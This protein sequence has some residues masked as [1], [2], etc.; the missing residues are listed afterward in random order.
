M[1]RIYWIDA[2][3]LITAKNGHYGFNLVPK[4]WSWIHKQIESGIVC[5]PKIAYKEIIDGNDELARWCKDRKGLGGGNFCVKASRDVQGR[6]TEIS[7]YAYEN[8]KLHQVSEFLRGADGWVIAHALDSHGF[9]VTEENLKHNQS[10]IK[11]PTIVKALNG[12]WKT[13]VDMCK[14]LG[15]AF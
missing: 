5:M 11:I 14:E 3:V 7:N 4:F 13:T 1:T 15:A 8:Y 2:G 9:V 12:T 6:Y 10:R